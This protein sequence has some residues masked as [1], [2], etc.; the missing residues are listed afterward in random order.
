MSLVF[1]RKEAVSKSWSDLWD[2]EEE[3]QENR[4]ML[5][6]K[7]MNSRTW[8]QESKSATTAVDDDNTP[9]LGLSPA[10]KTTTVLADHDIPSIDVAIGANIDE[11]LTADG[12]FFQDL[13]P[14]PKPE[15]QAYGVSQV[16]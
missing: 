16:G 10:T 4:E 2:E 3:E 8:S 7:E 1:G 9:R 12:F 11:D 14:P 6:L 5:A 13:P 15:V